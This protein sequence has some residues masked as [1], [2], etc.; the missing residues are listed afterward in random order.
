MYNQTRSRQGQAQE[1]VFG[2]WFMV[3]GL[4]LLSQDDSG[5]QLDPLAVHLDFFV[6]SHFYSLSLFIRGLFHA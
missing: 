5:Y 1:F 4:V 2:L 6:L 3:F